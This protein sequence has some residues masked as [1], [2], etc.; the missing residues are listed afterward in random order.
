MTLT[1]TKLVLIEWVDSYGC[2][3]DWEE[4]DKR[5][6]ES[7]KC[8]SVGWLVYD[9]EDCKTIVPHLC[10]M[11]NQGC[12]DMTIPTVAIKSVTVLPDLT[13][14]EQCKGS[15]MKRTAAFDKAGIETL[16]DDKPI[17]YRIK[18]NSGKDI[19]V[20][21]ARRGRAHETI[22]EHLGKI[23]GTTVTIL[24]FN[25]MEEAKIAEQRIINRDQP[26]FN[27]RDRSA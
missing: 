7:L 13:A 10:E 22:M 19:Y 12:G 11:K 4:L 20:G 5:T 21:A 8:R 26:K 17:V 3:S 27:R 18:K 23:P 16:A 1:K 2:S 14:A 25:S 15:D 9:G 6:R 24:V